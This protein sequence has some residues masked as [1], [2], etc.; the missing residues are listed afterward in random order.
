[1]QTGVLLSSQEGSW[2][3]NSDDVILLV[4]QGFIA[5]EV[6]FEDRGDEPPFWNLDMFR[7]ELNEMIVMVLKEFFATKVCFDDHGTGRTLLESV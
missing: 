6:C 2:M 7:V 1:M 4:W 5:M 3:I